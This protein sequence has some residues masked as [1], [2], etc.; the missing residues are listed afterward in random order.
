MFIKL[1]IVLFFQFERVSCVGKVSR[2][3]SLGAEI[4]TL[5]A[6]DL[7]ARW[8]GYTIVDARI[9]YFQTFF[10]SNM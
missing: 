1:L 3:L 4:L 5:S 8:K 9:S 2:A 6:L 7:D 10:Y